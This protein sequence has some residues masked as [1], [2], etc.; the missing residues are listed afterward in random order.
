MQKQAKSA[1]ALGMGQDVHLPPSRRADSRNW[2]L[3]PWNRWSF[4]RVQQFTRTTRVP[5]AEIPGKLAEKHRDFDELVFED[6]SGRQ[7]TVNEML[8]RTWTDGF[9]VMHKNAVLCERYFNAMR[10]DTLHLMM[11]CSKSFTSVLIGIYIHQ[12]ILE[13]AE[14][15][16]TYIPELHGTG[17][18][19]ATLQQALD[20]RVGVK[21]SEDYGDLD[22]DWRSCEV[23]TGWR[24]PEI[25]YC[26]PRDM[27][28]YM[29]TLN[30]RDS[31]HGGLFRYQS[32]LTN[33]LGI[34]LQRAS[35]EKFAELFH[36][37]IWNPVGAEHELVSIVDD[38]GDA[39]F[40]GGF[41]C[42]L[43]DFARFAQ[44]ICQGGLY[45]G[46]QLVPAQWIDECRFVGEELITAFAQSDYGEAMPN[47]AYHNQ[48]WLR[49][50]GRGVIM[51]MGIH[52]QTLY[53]DP[54]RDFIIAK[55]SSQ[56][57]Q[58]DMVMARDELLAFEAI[59]HA[60]A[61]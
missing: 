42:C 41:N 16:T 50:P 12:G 39:V 36:Q 35:G 38:A 7:C 32:I 15:L 33:A 1:D 56:P 26:G 61:G 48:W 55:F 45:Q 3:A 9:M 28:G 47:H 25:G 49:D 19:G 52:G 6:A 18:E 22:G 60:L 59:A 30:D 40:E 13:P 31:D 37:H 17:F 4:Q 23:A 5:R 27:V 2:T 20:M 43:R 14:L 29:Q 11:S 34:C 57:E 58:E 51:A 10:P 54:K 8:S 21:F 24:E 46:Q 53:I 44:M